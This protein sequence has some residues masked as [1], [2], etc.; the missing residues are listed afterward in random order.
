[1]AISNAD[2]VLH[3]WLQVTFWRGMPS[4]IP[5]I[6]SN[7]KKILFKYRQNIWL[8]FSNFLVLDAALTTVL[9]EKKKIGLLVKLKDHV[10]WYFILGMSSQ[11]M[12]SSSTN[13]IKWRKV[14]AWYHELIDLFFEWRYPSMIH[15]RNQKLSFIAVFLFFLP[16]KESI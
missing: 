4:A 15:Y 10:W 9:E 5:P 8:T 6:I 12:Y 7:T 11:H 1:M 16:S 2:R 13:V 3:W 14:M